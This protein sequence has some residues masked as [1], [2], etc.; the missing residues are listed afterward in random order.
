VEAYD[1][2]L[3]HPSRNVTGD[4]PA[5]LYAVFTRNSVKFE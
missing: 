3:A 2:T 4:Q 1:C 5:I